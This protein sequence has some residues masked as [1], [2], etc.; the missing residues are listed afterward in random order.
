MNVIREL[1]NT[2]HVDANSM[3]QLFGGLALAGGSYGVKAVVDKII[4]KTKGN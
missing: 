1:I 2:Y 4:N 3:G